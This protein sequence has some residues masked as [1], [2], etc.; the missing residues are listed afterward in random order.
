MRRQFAVSAACLL[1]S[2]APAFAVTGDW[3]TYGQDAGGKRFSDLRQL[4]PS[5]VADLKVA[6]TYHMRPAG[7]DGPVGVDTMWAGTGSRPGFITSQVTPLVVGGRMFITTPYKRVVALDPSTGKELWVYDLPKGNP[8]TRGLEYWPG[9]KK[10]APR[11]VFGTREGQL[12]VLDAATGQPIKSFG[13]NGVVEL[14]TPDVAHGVATAARGITYYGLTTPPSIYGDLIITGSSVQESPVVGGSGDVRAWDIRTGKLVWTFRSIPAKGEFGYD[15][16]AEGSTEGRSGVNVWGFMSVDAKRGIV[17]MPFGAPANDRWGG[18]RAGNNLFSSSIVAADAT[19]GKYLWHFQV[20]HHDIWDYDTQS[21]PLLFEAKVGG[22]SQPAVAITNKSGLLFVLNRVTGKPIFPIEE[23]AVPQSTTPGERTSPTQPYP[24]VTPPFGLTYFDVAK[25]AVANVTPELKAYC[26]NLVR[27]S[28]V[29]SSGLYTPPSLEHP[30]FFLPS[31][32]GGVDW[33]GMTFDPTRNLLFVNSN[34]RGSIVRQAK[35]EGFPPYNTRG[36][37]THRF[38]MEGTRMPC[39]PTPWGHMI[40]VDMN[41]GKF[42]WKS[43]LGVTDELPEAINKTGR[44][45]LGG[46]ISTAGGLVFVGGTD[47]ARFR[48]F[49]SANGKE[50]WTYK[51]PASAHATPMTYQAADRQFVAIAATGGGFLG[52]PIA[53]D[54]IVAFALPK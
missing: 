30:T 54:E 40:A 38:I 13:D 32:E 45:S 19:T 46:A 6:W 5:N 27:T 23:R 35:A 21:A 25:D 4:T 47:D 7:A 26:E 3:P 12:Y 43:V 2:A 48:A 8:S 16:W 18:D 15:T 20:T 31:T 50:V 41:T 51:L 34:T 42:A 22:K 14:R 44:P 39:L 17:Y 49:D 36:E 33:G 24:L 28:G 9:D 52:T 37:G 10:T 53:S 29:V 11:V 1:L